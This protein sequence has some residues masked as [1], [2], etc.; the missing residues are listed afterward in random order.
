MVTG[1]DHIKYSTAKACLD[2]HEPQA[3]FWQ[4]T[5]HATAYATLIKSGEENN[6]SCVKCHSLGLSDIKGFSRV[7]DLIEVDKDSFKRTTE[8]AVKE[9]YWNSV[10]RAFTPVK[11]IRKLSTKKRRAL[12]QSWDKIDSKHGINRNF[13]NVQCLNCHTKHDNHPW[14]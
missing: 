5:S 13:A 14:G 8:D 12:A 10:R 6:L 7:K 2:C 1:G 4:G 9:K 3:Q 11:S